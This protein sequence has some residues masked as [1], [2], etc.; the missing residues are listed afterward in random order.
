MAKRETIG[1]RL[2][3]AREQA[4]MSVP[5]LVQTIRDVHNRDVGESTVRDAENDKTPN[6]GIKTVEAMALG[7]RLDVLETISLGLD[8]SPEFDKGFKASQFGRLWSS[9]STLNKRRRDFADE[10]I[11]MLI[12]RIAH[13]Q[14]S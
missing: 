13:W 12:D 6:P 3:R 4:G 1:A 5:Q 9:Y 10:Y 11:Q 14:S 7:L 2:K 8:S